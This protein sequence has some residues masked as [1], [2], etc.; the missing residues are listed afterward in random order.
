ML[1]QPPHIRQR[2]PNMTATTQADV[3]LRHLRTFAATDNAGGPTE[4]GLAESF[5]YQIVIGR[6]A[7]RQNH[8]LAGK[9]A[10]PRAIF[11]RP[12]YEAEK[13]AHSFCRQRRRLAADQAFESGDPAQPQARFGTDP[14]SNLDRLSV[15]PCAGSASRK[16]NF[17]Q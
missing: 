17:K 13:C 4:V 7:G 16:P 10:A 3:I 12:N 2:A 5:G 8:R 14:L 11:G 9:Q 1:E 6:A 15:R